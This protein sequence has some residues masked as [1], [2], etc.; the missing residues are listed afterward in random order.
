MENHVVP[1]SMRTARSLQS[2]SLSWPRPVVSATAAVGHRHGI[3]LVG[4][5]SISAGSQGVLFKLRQLPNTTSMT[6]VFSIF[7]TIFTSLLLLFRLNELIS[8]L[9]APVP[10]HSRLRIMG[11]FRTIIAP[12]LSTATIVAP[13]Q[14]LT[15]WDLS[16]NS[17]C[18]SV[19]LAIFVVV[20]GTMAPTH[21]VP[22]LWLA[23]RRPRPLPRCPFGRL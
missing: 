14:H 5:H 10:T 21:L 11:V 9:S 22:V 17:C 16:D 2:P 19:R 3:I 13:Y 1:V 12:V 8:K 20:A 15:S 18:E 23:P 7:T 4:S 6:S